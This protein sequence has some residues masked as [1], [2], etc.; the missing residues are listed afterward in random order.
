DDRGEYRLFSL[1]PGKY[2]VAV[3]PED[4]T[5]RSAVLSMAPPVR[6][7]PS[8]QA[9]SPV[10][11]KRILPTG[12]TL[13]ETYNF[14]Y[15]GGTTDVKRATMLNVMPGATLGAIDISLGVGKTTALHIRGR[16]VDGTTGNPAAG[17]AVRLVPRTFNSYT[18]APVTV[19]DA[20]GHFDLAGVIAGNYH[21]YSLGAQPPQRPPAP[22]V[23]PPP[24]P[25]PLMAMTM[26][27]VG[28]E[29][30]ENITLKIGR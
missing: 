5:R 29:N 23:P 4:P 11:T 10:I 20:T 6:R 27:D 16:I 12:E 14:V 24:P 19:T 3:R 13:E 15:Y 25:I 7:G 22:G 1:V 17:A 30:I 2:Y 18:L 9:T 26:V 28:N 21:L 8:E